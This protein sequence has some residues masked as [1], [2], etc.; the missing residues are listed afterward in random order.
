MQRNGTPLRFEAGQRQEVQA[1]Q[2]ALRRDRPG[3]T[4]APV[5]I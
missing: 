5:R 1:Y 4:R 3:L 2:S